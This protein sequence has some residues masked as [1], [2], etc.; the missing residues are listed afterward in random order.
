MNDSPLEYWDW[1]AAEAARIGSDGCTGVS[2][3]HHPCCLEHDL[4]C[5]FGRDPRSAYDCYVKGSE[6]P[7]LDAKDQGRRRSDLKFAQCNFQRSESG[8]EFSRSVIRYLG[9]RVGAAFGIGAPPRA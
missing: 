4:A 2:E 7:W 6:N 5:H 9:V 8:W 3:W 1:I